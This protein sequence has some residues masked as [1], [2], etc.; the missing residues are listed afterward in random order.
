MLHS[1]RTAVRSVARRRSLALTVAVTLALGIGANAAIF[2]A[3]D[4]VLLKPLPF[5]AP[6]RLMRLHE[7]P[8]ARP[9]SPSL[10]APVRL[11]EWNRLTRSFDGLAGSYFEN[12]TETSGPL[13]ERL[14]AMRTSARFFAVLGV[15]AALGRTTSPAEE[16]HGGP[17]V[18]V[19]SH[20]YWRERFGSDPAI[21]GRA[22][23]VSGRSR[24]IVG[25]MPPAFRYP[26][27]ATQAWIPAQM[28]AGLLSARQARFY[29]AVGRLKAGVAPEAAQAELSVIQKRLGEAFPPTDRGWLAGVVPLKEE[30]VGGLR[31]SLWLLFGAVALVLLAACSNVACLQL[32]DGARREH[33]LAVRFALGAPRRVVVRQLLREGV[34]LAA[35]G[36]VGG[37]LVARAAIGLLR[38]AAIELPPSAELVLD[39]RL[40]A[41]TL[42]LGL[43]T[44][45]LFALLPALRA[46]RRDVADRLARGGRSH[47]GRGQRLQRAL[48]TLQIAVAVVL[49]AGSALLL[50]SFAQLQRVSPGFDPEGVLAFR[51]SASWGESP[52]S[53]AAR[54]LRTLDRLRDVPGVTA[55][56]ISNVLPGRAGY[57]PGEF[58]IAGRGG[59]ET[60]LALNRQVSAGYFAAMRIPLLEGEIC[61]D[62]PRLDAPRTTVVNRAFADR[63]FP[64]EPA[65]GR[66]LGDRRR[67]VGIV[68]DAREQGLATLP[69]PTLYNCGL[70]PYWPDPFFVVRTDPTRGVTMPDVRRALKE[71]EPGRAVYAA[72]TLTD[73]IAASLGQRRLGTIALG[74]FAA[75]ALGLVA[76][77]V[78]GMLA[79]HVAQRRREIGLRTAL[80]ARPLQLMTEIARYSSRVTLAGLALGL[81][82]ALAATG[83]MT[84]LVFGLSPR[85]PWTYVMVSLV[86]IG[87]A[88]GA[89][90]VPVSRAVRVDPVKTLRE[91]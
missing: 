90:I 29:T 37:L 28:Q 6:D 56:S 74:L 64:A 69:S 40:L 80:G 44:T 41:F 79:Q 43:A 20:A 45:I 76:V 16:I 35:A 71:I 22:L 24:T 89:T 81:G 84:S 26:D 39:A 14:A 72:S 46:T 3:I 13:P 36:A 48:V 57:P 42:S 65:I 53:V 1:W 5:P 34:V 68:G 51:M 83:S 32:A 27:D 75:M 61:R 66:T 15:P 21:V 47:V 87:I 25:V 18:A 7:V 70:L 19:I 60:L 11:E 10:V 9:E 4:A 63:F 8:E 52:E 67:I 91:E 85:D 55:A 17:A 12:M 50:R 38:T 58:T 33:E 31:R 59:D 62:D 23:V 82:G 77:G 88:A 73:T 78:Y 49:L 2:S 86:I 54:Q 30:Q